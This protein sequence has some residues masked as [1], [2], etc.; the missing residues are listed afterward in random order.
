VP[1][2]MIEHVS[3]GR[4]G[5]EPDTRCPAERAHSGDPD[6]DPADLVSRQQEVFQ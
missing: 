3:G 6:A 5:T 1:N 4:A 2:L